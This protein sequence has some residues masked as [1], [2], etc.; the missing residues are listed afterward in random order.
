MVSPRWKRLYEYC[1]ESGAIVVISQPAS[2]SVPCGRRRNYGSLHAASWRG[3]SR[4]RRAGKRAG[5]VEP[6]EASNLV[7]PKL[8]EADEKVIADVGRGVSVEEAF[9]AHRN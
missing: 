3:R 1:T 2:Q 5:C 6:N 4:G 8:V 7:P 9:Q